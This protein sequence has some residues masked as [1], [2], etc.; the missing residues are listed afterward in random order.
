MSRPVASRAAT[1]GNRRRTWLWVGL[2]AAASI[3]AGTLVLRSSG[4]VTPIT[5]LPPPHFIEETASAGI[6]HVYAGDFEFFVGGGVAVFDCD[7]DRRQDLYLAGGSA[8]AALYRNQSATGGALAFTRAES[9]VTDLDDVAG[10]YPID[11]DSDNLMDLVVVRVGENVILRGLG[12]CQFERA[13]EPWNIDGGNDWTAAFSAKWEEGNVLPTLAFGNYLNW[14]VN[15]EEVASCADNALFRPEGESYGEATALS[16]GWCTLSVLFAD[17]DRSGRADLR[18]ANDRHYYRDGS[19]Q[20][21]RIATGEEPRLYTAADGWG[22]IQIWGM[23]VAS[24]DVTGDGLPEF[25]IT[26]QADNKLRTL[27]GG[28]ERPTYDDIAIRRGVTAHRPFTG[29]EVLPS[30]AWHPEF[31]DVNNDGFLDLF[32]TK[33]NVESMAEYAMADPNN[34][35]LGQPDGTFEEAAIEAGVASLARSRGAALADFN[36]DGLLDLIVVNRTENVQIWRNEG[37]AGNWLALQVTQPEHNRDAVGA[38]IE[39]EIGDH[40][41]SREISIGGGHAGD[42]TG[43]MHFGLGDS[44]SATVRVLWPEGGSTA[45][46]DV[47]AGSFLV[48]DRLAAP[49]YWEPS[50]P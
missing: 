46:H 9:P 29:G 5:A 49:E 18:V 38:W 14:P 22:E 43:W 6:E 41:V 15:R 17:W 1:A 33:G 16:P 26:S 48:L 37:D 21:W 24:Q 27:E 7:D 23:G 50:Q 47:P 31:Q 13:N 35:L 32:I 40:V 20:L 2:G 39:V 10:A 25:F 45:A 36:L 34:L 11:I 19:E 3:T 42:Q 28:T 30:T 12:E 4:P 8:A 44:G